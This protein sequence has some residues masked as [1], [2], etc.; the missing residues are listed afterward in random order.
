[1]EYE[2]EVEKYN[3]VWFDNGMATFYSILKNIE[4]ND[5]L[6]KCKIK[7]DS[8]GIY[9]SFDDLN[10]FA[11]ALAG[12]INALYREVMITNET[13]KKTGSNKEYKKPH[14]LIQERA[15]KNG[16]VS[17]KEKIFNKSEAKE[18]IIK[19]YNGLKSGERTCFVCGRKFSS[20]YKSLQQA[21]YPFV[22]KI[23]SLSGVRSGRDLKL[24]EYVK[25]YCPQC[26]LIGVSEWLDKGMIYRNFPDKSIIILPYMENF[27]ELIDVKNSGSYNSS[28][29]GRNHRWTNLVSGLPT[30]QS[31]KPESTPGKY[32]TLVAFYN[33]FLYL[34]ERN[35]EKV[36]VPMEWYVL[37]TSSKNMKTPRI[38]RVDTSKSFIKV[39]SNLLKGDKPYFFYGG[40]V[41]NFFVINNK[42]DSKKSVFN[43][44]LGSTL[45]E[46][47]CEAIIKDDFGSF[48]AA[49]VPSKGTHIRL[50]KG[51][52]LILDK[53]IQEWRLGSMDE[54]KLKMFK[55][56]GESIA[57][58]I[59]ERMG[60]FFKLE[61]A[62]SKGD[63]LKAMEEIM[64]RLPIDHSKF[65]TDFNKF[66]SLPDE[67]KK[68]VKYVNVRKLRDFMDY[69]ITEDDASKFEDAKNI[70]LIY[71]SLSIEKY[72]SNKNEEG[73]NE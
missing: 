41:N 37:E 31:P 51:A 45:K 21:S 33:E 14:I 15:K 3:D 55:S 32:S 61:K 23:K 68:E 34:R 43:N 30:A 69:V 50:S 72:K 36:K 27:K 71:A 7:D 54:G 20:P 8:S 19:I 60:L 16:K 48:S 28:L 18:E 10:K 39:L 65:E 63:F 1:M 22:T 24:T 35:N 26:Y 25:D 5:E 9:Y 49:F 66:K 12:E 57:T 38:T 40:F 47:L 46:K 29:S 64:R 56:A 62:H 59:G 73:E 52:Y 44:D 6:V 70:L 42:P 58:L 13:D 4:E 67:K 11:A 2:F 53:I 17:L